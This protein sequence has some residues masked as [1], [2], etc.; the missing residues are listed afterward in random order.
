MRIFYTLITP[1]WA[2]VEWPRGAAIGRLSVRY[3]SWLKSAAYG[4]R[5][6]LDACSGTSRLWGSTGPVTSKSAAFARQN[7]LNQYMPLGNRGRV[8]DGRR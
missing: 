7:R 4:R 3:A 2:A 1:A 6:W 8:A 5:S